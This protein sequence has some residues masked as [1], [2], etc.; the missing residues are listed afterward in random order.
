MENKIKY[1]MIDNKYLS[2][3]LAFFGFRFMQF[4]FGKETKYSFEDSVELTQ[5][6]GKLLTIK[7][8]L[9]R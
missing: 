6:I 3:G 5:T 2:Q 7:K 8:E 9:G 1:R 4:G